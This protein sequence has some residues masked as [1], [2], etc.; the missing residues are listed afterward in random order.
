MPITGCGADSRE[1]H[2]KKARRNRDAPS[3]KTYGNCLL[4]LHCSQKDPAG[5]GVA[6]RFVV[7]AARQQGF[8]Q[9]DIHRLLW[10]SWG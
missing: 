8:Y 2:K 7:V 9:Q 6:A 1:R 10:M 3:N 5:N 4:G